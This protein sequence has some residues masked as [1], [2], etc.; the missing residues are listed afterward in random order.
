MHI[1]A[2]KPIFVPAA[3]RAEVEALSKAELMDMVWDYAKRC[4]DMPVM[5]DDAVMEE[6]RNTR[7]VILHYRKQAKAEGNQ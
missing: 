1:K 5:N 7:E 2:Q 6:F 3:H 4:S